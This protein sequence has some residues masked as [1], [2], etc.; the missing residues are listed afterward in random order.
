MAKKK[1]LPIP[2]PASRDTQSQEVIRAW[3]AENGL[4]CSLRPGI[5][6]EQNMN[7]AWA[8]GILLADVVRHVANALEEVGGTDPRETVEAVKESFLAEIA[9]PTS[10]HSGR[11]AR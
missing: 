6:F 2:P 5:W 1:S 10:R 3:I 11:F 4:H 8:W 7:E 9:N